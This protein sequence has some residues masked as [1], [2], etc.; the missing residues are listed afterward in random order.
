VRTVKKIPEKRN[1]KKAQKKKKKQFMK[2][3]YKIARK[4]WRCSG[5]KCWA[6]RAK[7]PKPKEKKGK[8][9]DNKGKTIR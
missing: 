8:A 1:R 3:E 9:G 5:V 4:K 2:N 7:A 6:K